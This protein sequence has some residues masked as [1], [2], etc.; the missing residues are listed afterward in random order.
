MPTAATALSDTE[1]EVKDRL[2]SKLWE[3][4]GSSSRIPT[5]EVHT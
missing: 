3:W 4:S 1:V 5:T 2:S